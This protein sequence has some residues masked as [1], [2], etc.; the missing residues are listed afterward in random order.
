MIR[1]EWES[2]DY[3]DFSD[4]LSVESVVTLSPP[5]IEELGI[6]RCPSVRI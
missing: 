4:F 3:T 6:L 5:E 1:K 2:T